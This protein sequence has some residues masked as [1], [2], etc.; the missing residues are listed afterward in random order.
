MHELCVP[1][2]ACWCLQEQRDWNGAFSLSPLAPSALSQVEANSK[3]G[4]PLQLGRPEVLQAR[5]RLSLLGEIAGG[6]PT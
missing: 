2:C 3:T 6:R 5:F 1:E 4:K